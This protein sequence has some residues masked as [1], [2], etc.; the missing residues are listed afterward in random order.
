VP[1][2]QW[3]R[4]SAAIVGAADI[5]SPTGEI[6]GTPRAI[7][8][9]VI[10]EAL[11]DA[12]LTIADVDGV[13]SCTG[14]LFMPSVELAEYLGV[15]ASWTDATQTGGSSFEIM[16]EH[17]AAA[18][19]LGMADVVVVSYVSTPRSNAKRGG[20]GFSGAAGQADAAAAG[21]VAP[22]LEWEMPF[23]MQSP[24]GAY[25]LAASRHQA[26]YGTTP[27]QMAQ[28]A[29]DTRAWAALNPKARYRTPLTIDDVLASPMVASPLHRFDC[30]L[31][32]DG[33]GAIVLTSAERARSLRRPP[34]YVLGA[35]S[36]HSHQMISQMPEVTVTAGSVSGPAA[37]ELAGLTPSDVDVAELYDSFTITVLLALEDLGFCKKGEGG[38]FVEDG[39]LGPGGA[40]PAQT[41]GGGLSYTHPGMFGM[42]LLVEATRQLQGT[43]GDRQVAGAEVAVAHGVG[44]VL[45]A[46]S[47]IV[48]GT[49]ATL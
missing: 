28:I 42:F 29:V 26:L 8:M 16:V 10:K 39:K 24:V 25:A 9:A 14:G 15:Q 45:S 32:T 13:A 49:E 38:A 1:D 17:A 27:E 5:V 40:F 23:G 19:Q 30:C 2:H 46:T 37:F 4:G 6:E 35:S 36:A 43:A 33:A 18:I 22:R 12:G 47:T 44:G 7:E 21:V 20:R 11:D 41:S 3:A 31:V 48:L 34:A